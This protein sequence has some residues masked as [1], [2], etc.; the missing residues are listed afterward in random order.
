MGQDIG[1]AGGKYWQCQPCPDHSTQ[2]VTIH[3]ETPP[4]DGG[5]EKVIIC[6]VEIKLTT[7]CRVCATL[8]SSK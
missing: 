4:W 6:L 3:N 1:L 5:M 7:A 2:D 8:D